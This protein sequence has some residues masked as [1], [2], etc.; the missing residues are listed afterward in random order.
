MDEPQEVI[1]Q[2]AENPPN[3]YGFGHTPLYADVID[4]IEK[5]R[6]PYVTAEAGKRAL[7]LV[8]AIYKSAAEG[9]KVKLPLKNCSTIDFKGR[10]DE[11]REL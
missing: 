8:L 9:N 5:D 11:V 2:F 1:A 4:A 3:V 6:E 10:F 7:E